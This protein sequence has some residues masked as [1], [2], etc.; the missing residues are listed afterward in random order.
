MSNRNRIIKIDTRNANN[1]YVAVD[2][3]HDGL[4]IV[5]G[6]GAADTEERVWIGEGD[7]ARLLA[8]IRA[9]LSPEFG[10]TRGV[11]GVDA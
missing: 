10:G 1:D 4:W 6:D 8:A 7:A 2:L 5:V 11:G 3:Q 9:N